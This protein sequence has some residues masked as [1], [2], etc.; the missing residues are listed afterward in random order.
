V[1]LSPLVAVLL[2]LLVAPAG[3]AAQG[4]TAQEPPP[5]RCQA[6]ERLAEAQPEIAL[7]QLKKALDSRATQDCAVDQL[8]ALADE[9]GD[10]AP[11]YTRCRAGRALLRQDQIEAA[12]GQFQ[13]AIDADPPQPCGVSGMVAVSRA[14]DQ[15]K[16]DDNDVTP[17]EAWDD[18]VDALEQ[19][20][21]WLAALA[22]LT[23]LV[24]LLRILGPKRL[25]VHAAK[26]DEELAKRVVAA[27]NASVGHAALPAKVLMGPAEALP[28]S[29]VAD[30]SK[31]LRLPGTAPLAE[32]MR[33][34]SWLVPGSLSR[35]EV[36]SAMAGGWAVIE[37]E[38]RRTFKV[39]K[40]RIALPLGDLDEKKQK[41]VLGLAGGAWLVAEMLRDGDHS[42]IGGGADNLAEYHACFRAGATSQS[43]GELETARA[44]YAAMT[45]KVS[46][47]SAPFAWLGA[48]L[49]QMMALKGERRWGE[50]VAFAREVEAQPDGI[51]GFDKDALRDLMRRRRY[52]TAIARVDH[53]YYL[54]Q[55]G[56]H[57]G[58]LE[59][60]KDAAKA[61][62]DE[63]DEEREA[64]EGDPAADAEGDP[65][66][67]PDDADTLALR[68]AIRMVALCFRI[69]V[70]GEV[71]IDHVK[72]EL[73]LSTRRPLAPQPLLGAAAYYDAACAVSMLAE[74]LPEGPERNDHFEYGFAL[75]ETVVAATPEA[76]LPRVRAM[77][78]SDDMLDP[79]RESDEARF[80]KILK[81]E[82][83]PAPA[84]EAP[85][86][87]DALARLVASFSSPGA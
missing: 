76:R 31:L 16:D 3:A 29:Q 68:A 67:E 54:K 5:D 36:S 66:P 74:R 83:K 47:E 64:A 59:T 48:R 11:L 4:T 49:N 7:E 19:S 79:L 50:M 51:A 13:K 86:L 15:K 10:V 42:P 75:L 53:F 69:A 34:A 73:S 78:M 32:L 38:L 14:E 30:L 87:G 71:T 84:A 37:L 33:L 56:A 63:L 62:V 27:A 28:D 43:R 77:A 46:F 22:L 39:R 70:D 1:R 81:E 18:I 44:C 58:E 45:A 82:A 80:R 6:A 35:L 52:M 61:A 2:V 12:K 24:F 40:A 57:G 55:G 65:P 23:L 26:D 9:E 20:W 8:V 21:P 72:D 85:T 17:G 25:P 60:A 41:E